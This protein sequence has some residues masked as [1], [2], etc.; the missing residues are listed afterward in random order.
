MNTP[1]H[2]REERR[3]GM[4]GALAAM[5]ALV[6]CAPAAH[7]Q[8][9]GTS[10]SGV[11]CQPAAGSTDAQFRRD[12]RGIANAT[13]VDQFVVCGVPITPTRS[14]ARVYVDLYG[15]PGTTAQC[16]LTWIH[17]APGAS[18]PVVNNAWTSP[19]VAFTVA[20]REQR[21]SYYRETILLLVPG[22]SGTLTCRL[23]RTVGLVSY[24]FSGALGSP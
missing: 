13:S 18:V 24:T 1:M 16:Q 4:A 23:G 3:C 17:A 9:A 20:A 19:L 7:A 5:A 21:I 6:L 10:H 11:A 12:T 15:D 14:N 22:H 8:L 2:A